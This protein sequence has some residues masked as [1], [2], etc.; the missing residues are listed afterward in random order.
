MPSRLISS[1][2]IFDM[3]ISMSYSFFVGGLQ[4]LA[5]TPSSMASFSIAMIPSQ[6]SRGV[7]CNLIVSSAFFFRLLE[8]LP[9]LVSY[10]L[11]VGLASITIMSSMSSMLV[12]VGLLM[13]T[14]CTALPLLAICGKQKFLKFWS[15]FKV[16]FLSPPPFCACNRAL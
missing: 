7:S 2:S 1:A 14:S 6:K 15:D 5:L 10:V 11:L 8:L 9:L 13:T 4:S 12:S 3:P 16:L